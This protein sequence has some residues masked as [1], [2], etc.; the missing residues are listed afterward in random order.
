M[1]T[2]AYVDGNPVTGA[3]PTGLDG[4]FGFDWGQYFHDAGQV[5]AGEASALNPFAAVKGLYDAG[6][7]LYENRFS[8]QSAKN[9][10]SGFYNGIAFWDKDDPHEFGSSFM[11]FELTVAPVVKKIPNFTKLALTSRIPL[12]SGGA[13]LLRAD[14]AGEQLI[15][16]DWHKLPTTGKLAE[17]LPAWARGKNLPHYHRPGPGGKAA[18]RPWDSSGW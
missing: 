14:W 13:T 11:S 9:L 10:G 7:H 17:K 4:W 16:F 18:H 5:L 3:D 8:L 12:A 1:N 6:A 2:Y 15:R